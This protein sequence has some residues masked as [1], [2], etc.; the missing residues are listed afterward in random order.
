MTDEEL[1][2]CARAGDRK[3]FCALVEKYAKPL[4]M[5]I[6]RMVKDKDDAMDIS[7]QV[8]LK[9]YERLSLFRNSSSFKTWLYKVAVNA[10]KDHVR[11]QKTTFSSDA[12]DS[13]ADP[14]ESP[15]LLLEKKQELGRIREAVQDLPEKQR[16]TLQLRVYEGL[17]YEEIAKILGGRANAAKA[18]LCEAVKTLRRKLT[19]KKQ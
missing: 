10:V 7:Q 13:L 11:T 3:A 9:T 8:F 1:V 6:L 18:N 2:N 14:A 15:A 12:L 19:A 16:M 4:T 5:M 17:E